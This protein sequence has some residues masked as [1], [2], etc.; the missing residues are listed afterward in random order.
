MDGHPPVGE[1]S[2]PAPAHRQADPRDPRMRPPDPAGTRPKFDPESLRPSSDFRSLPAGGGEAGEPPPAGGE[3]PGAEGPS[4]RDRAELGE[5][6]EPP[7]ACAPVPTKPSGPIGEAPHAPRFQFLLGAFGALG[8]AAI[9]L[10]VSL[11][12]APK[13]KPEAQWSSWKPTGDVDPAT[14]IA[15][16]VETEYLLSPGH[17]LV[18]VSGGPQEI[19][20]QP[21]ALYIRMS[22][23]K[24]VPLEEQG[25]FYQ[26][27]GTESNCSI[28]GKPS[29]QRGLLVRREALEL[30][31]YTFRYISGAS[32]VVVTFPPP[33]P[34]S[35]KSSH[36]GHS[37]SASTAAN[38]LGSSNA[39]EGISPS[40]HIPS[41][42]LLFR[43]GDLS[44]ELS[45]PL[46]ATLSETTPTVATIDSAPESHFV[47]QLTGPLVYDSTLITQSSSPVLLLQQA[48]IGS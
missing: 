1:P 37:G 46:G 7:R 27:C 21:V 44:P 23:E 43:P 36:S 18:G 19:D 16:H 29:V 32:Q 26:L 8:V 25:V 38:G 13:P 12:L 9:V 28:P 33:S 14:Q 41:R 42:V 4:K 22:G 11:A 30:A 48:S 34:S 10:A 3:S 45:R 40:S 31:L 20:G 24:P 47:E 6:L 15:E 35:G 5:A 39:L 17:P 2:R